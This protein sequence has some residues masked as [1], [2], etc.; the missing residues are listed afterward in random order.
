MYADPENEQVDPNSGFLCMFTFWSPNPLDPH[1]EMPGQK[2]A[3]AMYKQVSPGETCLCGSGKTYRNCC[4]PR[5]Y[6]YPICSNPG[7]EG[8]SFYVPCS[9]TFENIAGEAIRQKMMADERLY[10]V[11]DEAHRGFWLFWG[12]PAIED[13]E[14][15]IVCFGDIEL[16]QNHT[17][18]LTAISELRLQALLNLLQEVAGEQLVTPRIQKDEPNAIDKQSSGQVQAPLPTYN[19]KK[20]QVMTPNKSEKVPR[21]MQPKF[22]EI[23]SLTDEFC[24][25]HLNEEYAEMSR[26]MT[27][28]LARKR[29]SPLSRGKAN[30]WACGIVYALGQVNF[31]FDKSQT[32]HIRPDGLCQ[33]F[34]IA[35]STGGNKAKQI[36]DL[37]KIH[38]FD[39]NWTLPRL[40]D[41]TPMVWTIS[42]NGFMVDARHMPREIQE[43][44]YRKGLIPYIP[45]DD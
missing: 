2:Q 35:Q 43:E 26:K 27:A 45:D 31:L 29:P 24:K 3:V 34:N 9:A 42:V 44:A 37:L 36:R 32:P 17:L 11:E 22:N 30:S 19:K 4:R 8:Y 33:V 20:G 21:A 5:R 40:I 18:L 14:F 6:W 7:M 25:Q 12:D 16:K 1:P 38:I 39:P 28:A 15:G 13:E 41:S 10:C 23:V